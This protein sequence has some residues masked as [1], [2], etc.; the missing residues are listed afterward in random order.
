MICSSCRKETDI[1]DF[2]DYELTKQFKTC[3]YCRTKDKEYREKS[4]DKRKQY[5]DNNKEK[6]KQRKKEYADNNKEKI[7]EYANKIKQENPLKLKIRNMISH[8]KAKD[9][10]KN[11]T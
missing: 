8:S 3:L 10:I 5:R 6:I 11:R 4:K 2:I 1:I 7:K 9:K